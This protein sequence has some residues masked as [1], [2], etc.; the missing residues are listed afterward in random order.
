[1]WI[2]YSCDCMNIHIK[3]RHRARVLH[4][5]FLFKYVGKNLLIS[6]GNW[7]CDKQSAGSRTQ[8]NFQHA[9]KC[10]RANGI[11]AP[12]SVNDYGSALMQEPR[13]WSSQVRINDDISKVQAFCYSSASFRSWLSQHRME[14][15]ERAC[16]LCDCVKGYCKDKGVR[17]EVQQSCSKYSQKACSEG[18]KMLVNRKWGNRAKTKELWSF[19]SK[20]CVPFFKYLCFV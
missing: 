4:T 19:Q 3:L 12:L 5:G 17:A 18:A 11:I 9:L 16:G 10:K 7:I 20:Y 2:Y 1:M 6:S 8:L 15:P 14:L 13:N